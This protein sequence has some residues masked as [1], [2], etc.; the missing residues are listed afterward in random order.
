MT[1]T[2]KGYSGPDSVG[3]LIDSLI[4]RIAVVCGNAQGVFEEYETVSECNPVV[5]AVNDVGVYLPKVD[6]WVSYHSDKLKVW[7]QAKLTGTVAEKRWTSHTG[8]T[9]GADADY[10]WWGLEPTTFPLSGQLAMLIAFLMGAE[11]IILCGCPNNGT[12]RFFESAP[13]VDGFKYGAGDTQSDKAV[14][15]TYERECKRVPEL[16]ARVRSMSGW[17][18][19]FFGGLDDGE[20]LHD[21][22]GASLGAI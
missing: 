17:T 5:F 15:T 13:R 3:G 14:I 6:H 11:R 18:Y 19:K 16:K 4:G 12:P 2:A 20:F 7:E 8:G 9:R 1:W 22:P 21:S 10:N